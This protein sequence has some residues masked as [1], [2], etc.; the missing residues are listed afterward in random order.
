MIVETRWIGWLAVSPDGGVANLSDTPPHV[1]IGAG[2]K[3]ARVQFEIPA[4]LLDPV[5]T[6]TVE[7]VITLTAEEV[8]P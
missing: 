2:W 7:Q 3:T 1:L 4:A 5:I 8:Q 6:L